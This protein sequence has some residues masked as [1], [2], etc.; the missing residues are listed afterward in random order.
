MQGFILGLVFEIFIF[1][2]LVIVGTFVYNQIIVSSNRLFNLGEVLPEDEIHSL[3]QVFYL[4][5]MGL[6]FIEMLYSLISSSGWIYFILFDIILS[7]FL[8]V[9]LD[10]SSLK[11]KLIVLLLVPFDSLNFLFFNV[12]LIRFIDII[13]FL[14]FIYFIRMYYDKFRQ[15]TES[16][17]L[18][19]TILVLFVLI[20]I[21]FIITQI[22]EGVN[23]LDSLVMVSNA[24]TSNGYAILG[25]SMAG[26]INSLALVWG[27]Y[28]LSGVGTATLTAAI[29]MRHFNHKFDEM[30]KL[31][32]NNVVSSQNDDED[33]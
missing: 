25:D 24:F 21:S 5:M 26:K 32:K 1:V 31:I 14:I 13:H 9:T 23:P 33:S 19:L 20:F 28:I 30:E 27:G 3:K 17:G 16:N 10:K 29:L 2:V 11:G 22:V 12:F 7:L 15:Y 18:S 4:I 6:A 8:A